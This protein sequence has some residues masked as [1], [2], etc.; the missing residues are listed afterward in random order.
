MPHHPTYSPLYQQI[1]TTLLMWINSGRWKLNQKLPSEPDL[2]LELNVSTGTIRKALDQ[3][4]NEKVVIRKQGKGTYLNE[5][6]VETNLFLYFKFYDLV[7]K[8]IHPTSKFISKKTT[9]LG[10]NLAKH[11]NA[12]PNEQALTITRLRLNNNVPLIYETITLP[13]SIYGPSI[14]REEIP[15]TLYQFLQKKYF[16]TIQKAHETISIESPTPEIVKLLAIKPS[17]QLLKIVRNA[18][19]LKGRIVEHRVT[20]ANTSLAQ[21]KITLG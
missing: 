7:G 6:N 16:V 21:Y 5:L 13:F 1:Y 8:R 10:N 15:N 2:A 4:S 18:E 20:F 3:L 19:D 11:F 17:C 12:K 14:E 9:S